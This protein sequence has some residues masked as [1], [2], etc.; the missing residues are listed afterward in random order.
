MLYCYF[1]SNSLIVYYSII[2]FNINT[3]LSIQ[4]LFNY[5]CDYF[6]KVIE[7]LWFVHTY[8]N[9][10]MYIC[11]FLSANTNTNTFEKHKKIQIRVKTL[12]KMYFENTKTNTFQTLLIYI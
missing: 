2:K 7:Q 6:K 4:E 1:I 3:S 5:N 11:S 12:Q 10:E 9:A 8:I